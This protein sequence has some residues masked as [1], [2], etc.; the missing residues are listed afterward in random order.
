M[1]NLT[2]R[3]PR[4]TSKHP[5][6]RSSDSNDHIHSTDKHSHSSEIY[7]NVMMYDKL[8]EIDTK[9][10]ET[11]EDSIKNKENTNAIEKYSDETN[12]NKDESSVYTDSKVVVENDSG[13]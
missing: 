4:H 7:G 11:I 13:D 2:T 5:V 8:K 12:I 3:I 9:F 10:W 6:S 1:P